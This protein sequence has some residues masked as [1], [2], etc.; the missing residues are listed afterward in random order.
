MV[1]LFSRSNFTVKKLSDAQQKLDEINDKLK[2]LTMSV[3]PLVPNESPIDA[4]VRLLVRLNNL[5]IEA[6]TVHNALEYFADSRNVQDLESVL[7]AV[8]DTL[9]PACGWG[10]VGSSN[11]DKTCWRCT[12]LGR[13]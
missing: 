12:V 13:D 10:N 1:G 2:A 8:R 3:R 6:G 7:D 5:Y 4:L 9:C 11:K